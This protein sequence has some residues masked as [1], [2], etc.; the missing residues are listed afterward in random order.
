MS[1]LS[2]LMPPNYIDEQTETQRMH[3]TPLIVVRLN[4]FSSRNFLFLLEAGYIRGGLGTSGSPIL[5]G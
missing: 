4:R 5:A 2:P 3:M 1:Y